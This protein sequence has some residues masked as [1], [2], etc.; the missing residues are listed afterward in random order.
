M[1]IFI[2]QKRNRFPKKLRVLPHRGQKATGSE[3]I[4]HCLLSAPSACCHSSTLRFSPWSHLWIFPPHFL[5]SNHEPDPG[6]GKEWK[7]KEKKRKSFPGAPRL[8]REIKSS[9]ILHSGITCRENSKEKNIKFSQMPMRNSIF[10]GGP[11]IWWR[12]HCYSK[13]AADFLL[14]S[15]AYWCL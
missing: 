9:S 3:I 15:K 6:S 10:G 2:L 1:I 12:K 14:F 13:L 7:T 5:S 8:G 4:T 11:E